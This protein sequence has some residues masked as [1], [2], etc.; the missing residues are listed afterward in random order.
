M[1]HSWKVG[2]WKEGKHFDLWHINHFLAGFLLGC[3]ALI[4]DINLWFGFAVS[5]ILMVAWEIYELFAS[6][7][8]TK[9][10]MIIDVVVGV[11]AYWLIIFLQDKYQLNAELIPLFW[12]CLILYIFLELWGFRAYKIRTRAEKKA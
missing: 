11:V 10:N 9:F 4:F 12:Q 7:H 2:I 8:E 6:I 5:L 1:E 3:L